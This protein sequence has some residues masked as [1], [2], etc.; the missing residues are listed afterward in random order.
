MGNEIGSISRLGISALATTTPAI[1][2][3]N[4]IALRN[5]LAENRLKGNKE[6]HEDDITREILL[7]MLTNIKVFFTID[8]T[9]MSY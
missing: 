5:L 4:L 2:S 8:S 1:E 3:E 6:G 7:D 9:I